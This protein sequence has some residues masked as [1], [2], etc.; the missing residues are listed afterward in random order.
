MEIRLT[1]VLLIMSF[2][3]GTQENPTFNM[4]QIKTGMVVDVTTYSNQ[5]TSF[6]IIQKEKEPFY[7]P[8]NNEWIYKDKPKIIHNNFGTFYLYDLS[9]DGLFLNVLGYD[10]LT[11]E[12]NLSNVTLGI[13]DKRLFLKEDHFSLPLQNKISLQTIFKKV[14]LSRL[15]YI[16]VRTDNN[17]TFSVDSIRFQK[18]NYCNNS[19]TKNF[20]VW[21]WQSK[22]IERLTLERNN[23]K[24]IYMANSL[25]IISYKINFVSFWDSMAMIGNRYNLVVA[26]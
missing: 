14:N 16:V 8:S 5:K 17:N 9:Y 11:I 13:A 26:K 2:L 23:I 10:T 15:K 12:A 25:F 7:T 18:T 24:Y 3:F 22:N 21:I 20:S 1:I 4:S 19:K 6:E